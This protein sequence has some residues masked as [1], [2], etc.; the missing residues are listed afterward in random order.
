MPKHGHFGTGAPP[1][2]R[3]GHYYSSMYQTIPSRRRAALA[4]QLIPRGRV[5]QVG[6]RI[7]KNIISHM[8]NKYS[9]HLLG[10]VKPGPRH[11]KKVFVKKPDVI[12]ERWD[13]AKERKRRFKMHQMPTPKVDW[14]YRR[15]FHKK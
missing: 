5:T 14:A 9:S 15:S 8:N 13:A 10:C 1:A 12:Q 11:L 6:L 7:G 3:S 2:R 4:R